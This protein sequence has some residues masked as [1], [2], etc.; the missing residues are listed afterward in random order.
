[1]DLDRVV[2]LH[3]PGSGS[4]GSGCLIGASVILTAAHV[5]GGLGAVCRW[6]RLTFPAGGDS[7]LPTPFLDAEVL[8]VS[9]ERDTALL[10]PR[11]GGVFV[12]D[13]GAARL[14]RPA[15]GEELMVDA[16]GFP[17]YASHG[18]QTDL[19]QLKA[20][21][22]AATG[23]RSGTLTLDVRGVAP[24]DARDWKGISGGPVFAGDALVA[25]LVHV[26]QGLGS[27]ALVAI[28]VSRLAEDQ[29][30]LAMLRA[31]G[32]ALPFPVVDAAQLAAIPA[33][34]HWRGLRARYAR[35]VLDTW[36]QLDRSGLPTTG[37]AAAPQGR[38]F[39]TAMTLSPVAPSGGPALG[40]R[41]LAQL[42]RAAIT[43]Q[44]G[45]GKSTA[46]KLALKIASDRPG[47]VPIWLSLAELPDRGAIAAPRLVDV[48]VEQARRQLLLEEVNPEFFRS[49]LSEGVAAIAFDGLD[50]AGGQARRQQ[51]RD[52]I[53]SFSQTWPACRMWLGSRPAAY[54]EGPFPE[55]SGTQRPDETPRWPRLDVRPLSPADMR[56]FLKVAADDDGTL[57]AAIAARDDLEPLTRT[58][59]TLTMLAGVAARQGL[60]SSAASVFER[61]VRTM[62]VS[63]EEA[64]GERAS[65]DELA[66]RLDALQVLA[67]AVQERGEPAA[68]F[69][70][71]LARQALRE[72]FGGVSTAA[73]DAMLDWAVLRSGLL[74]RVSGDS[75]PHAAPLLQ[76]AHLQIQ[77]FLAGAHAAAMFADD[78]S[79]FI[80]AM[81]GKWY[82][83]D[84]REPLGFAVS[85]M[86]NDGDL[87]NDLLR[88]VR[89][90]D[91][92]SEDLLHRRVRLVAWLL[93]KVANPERDLVAATVSQL[94]VVIDGRGYRQQDA[95]AALIGLARHAEARAPLAA[96]AAGD[97]L[98]PAT[99]GYGGV[100]R[101]S[102]SYPWRLRAVEALAR[103]EGSAAGLRH[104][105]LVEPDAPDLESTLT[106]LKLRS[107]WGDASTARLRLQA[108]FEDAGD[109]TDRQTIDRV[110]REVGD[111]ETADALIDRMLARGP[112]LADLVWACQRG[113]IAPTNP[114]LEDAL[115]TVHRTVKTGAT[116]FAGSDRLRS[117]LNPAFDLV[118]LQ[119]TPG[120]LALL[121]STLDHPDLLWYLGPRI[122]EQVPELR[123]R[124]IAAMADYVVDVTLTDRSRRSAVVFAL[125]HCPD[126]DRIVPVL[127]H[128]LGQE[129]V[130]RWEGE[131]IADAL[132]N[133]GQ[134]VAALAVLRGLLKH[135]TDVIT[136]DLNRRIVD[137]AWRL[138]PGALFGWLDTLYRTGDPVADARQL[139]VVWNR[140]GIGAVA[141]SW[142]AH[143]LRQD[144]GRDFLLAGADAS[145]DTPFANF[146]LRALA[147]SVAADEA[148]GDRVE[149]SSGRELEEKFDRADDAWE[150]ATILGAMAGIGESER[151]VR[152]ADGWL[153]TAGPATRANAKLIAN[154]ISALSD[155]DFWRPE[156]RDLLA[157]AIRLIDRD[158][159]RFSWIAALE[160]RA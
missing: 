144:T 29:D 64:K 60:P 108:L 140:S 38:T 87:H 131:R 141:Q 158:D 83:D 55:P 78:A 155:S 54:D 132:L 2:E 106:C 135:G 5:V 157:S 137:V 113:R 12:A 112:D 21:I 154:R 116:D 27:A 49:L 95:C 129:T 20:S 145:R 98:A 36:C 11:G 149:S 44:P 138:D 34:G 26:P 96:M 50:E 40:V 80:G 67:W 53:A 94:A 14:A 35:A 33:S 74:V 72:I 147:G 100:S 66:R 69:S 8:W 43:G 134:G 109:L 122:V 119:C 146:A 1:M 63:W 77:E 46:L 110:L 142:F 107:E 65:D 102:V 70:R 123:P 153:A 92:P 143:V 62:C 81:A 31:T 86:A 125:C 25:H 84:W 121:E 9:E 4:R 15:I 150:A 99:P 128:L 48:L 61:W 32:I 127:L 71:Q 24:T 28:P 13:V 42:P 114:L 45:A 103:A 19:V 89:D 97:A 18:A 148:A 104:L 23:V 51:V 159:R 59:L 82:R 76:F 90:L 124:A 120:L 75:S 117:D 47:T 115:A 156:W 16:A 91:E 6:R 58:P 105:E 39:Y 151:A 3:V 7:A 57:A 130:F 10:S 93:S 22:N 52:A 73:R 118:Q 79:G 41:D 160:R 17:R 111:V 139:E 136:E 133:R 56:E 85:Q 37:L 68:T 152:L 126:E 101:S 88:A 30:A